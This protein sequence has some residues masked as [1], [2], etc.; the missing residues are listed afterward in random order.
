MPRFYL[1]L[2][3]HRESHADGPDAVDPGGRG[4]LPG[5]RGAAADGRRGRRQRSSPATRR[6]RPRRGPGWRRSGFELFA[7]PRHRLE[8][9]DRGAASPTTSTGRRSTA[10]SSGAGVVLAGGQGKL[11]GKIFRVGHLGSVTLE[12]ILGAMS[13]ARGRLARSTAARSEP[14]VGGRGRA[15]R[16]ARVARHR[17]AGG[18]RSGCVRVL[19]AEPLASE[20]VEL[21]RAAPRGRRAAR[22]VARRAVRDPARLRRAG[23]PQPGPGRR[24]ADRRRDRGWW[25]SAG[26]ASAS[27]TSTSTPRRGPG[28]S[29]STPRPATRSPPPSTRS[30]CSTALARRIAAA[31]ASVRRGEW[32]RAAVHR[33]SSCAA[34][35]SGIVGLGKIGQAIAVRARAHG[36]DRPR[37]RP[38]RDRRAGRQPRRRARR[39]STSS[40]RAPTS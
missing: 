7:D 5:R 16:G 17:H 3:A 26:P 11:T 9:R 12:E 32:K 31:D 40:S 28:S 15:G 34:G 8:D 27:T 38:V 22:P 21:L 30:P 18:R 36:D 2:R 23:R 4:R 10:R 33:A 25:S 35:R 37:R 6:A 14:G 19:V 20:G 24:R 13:V 29:S 1:D 39:R